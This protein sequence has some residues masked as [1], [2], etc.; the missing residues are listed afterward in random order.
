MVLTLGLWRF[1]REW[2]PEKYGLW[3]CDDCGSYKCVRVRKARLDADGNLDASHYSSG[4]GPSDGHR[5]HHHH[6]HHHTHSTS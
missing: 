3:Q 1:V 6:H 4:D 5:H 2:N